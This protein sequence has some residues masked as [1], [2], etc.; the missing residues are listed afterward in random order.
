MKKLHFFILFFSL[1]LQAQFQI[2]GV[3]KQVKKNK[4]IP[5]AIIKTN[6]NTFFLADANGAFSISA[7][8]KPTTLHIQQAGFESTIIPIDDA[9]PFYTVQLNSIPEN[10]S[11]RKKAAAFVYKIIGAKK[12]NNPLQKLNN[13][14]FKSY[15][16]LLIT[17][18]YDS[19]NGTIDSIFKIK[20]NQRVLKKIDS[21]NYK[22]KKL[23]TK[24]DLYLTEKVSQFDF[25]GAHF[26]ERVL[27]SKMAGFKESI[28]EYLS[29][30][31]Q[32]FSIYDDKYELFSV[33][34][35]SPI[36]SKFSKEYEFQILDSTV[37]DNRKV[38]ILHFKIKKHIKTGLEGILY[39]DNE[40]FAV[41][42][43]TFKTTG[44]IEMAS[45]IDFKYQPVYK[46][47]FP[48]EKKILVEKGDSEN[49]FRFFGK[50]IAFENENKLFG[51][52][53]KQ[54][55]D[56]SYLESKTYYSDFRFNTTLSIQQ[57]SILID[58]P[59]E[60]NTQKEDFWIANRKE[61]LTKRE[62][63][64]YK[65]LDSLSLLKKVEKRIFQGRK[66]INGYFPLSFFD[67]NLRALESFNNYE[68]FRFGIGGKTNEKLSKIYKFEFYTAY[69]TRDGKMK[70]T[71][72][73]SLRIGGFSDSWVGF[74]YA[75]DINE[76]ANSEF[77]TEKK[78]LPIYTSQPRNF[79]TFYNYENWSGYIETKIIPKTFSRWQI[80]HS[81]VYPKFNYEF[82]NKGKTYSNFNISTAC[83]SIQWNPFS[84]YMQTPLGK[85]EIKK[86]FPKFT[87]QFTQ[88]LPENKF[89]TNDFVFTKIDFKTI[90]EKKYLNGQKL[91]IL[92]QTGIGFGNIPIT[93]LYNIGQNSLVNESF[94]RRLF[95]LV[96]DTSFE[97]MYFNEFYSNQYAY[98]QARYTFNKFKIA[99]RMKPRLA[100]VSRAAWGSLNNP[101]NHLLI[102]IKTLEKGFFE[103]GLEINK[104][105]RI[106]G[107][108][109]FYRYGPNAL[110]NFYDNFAAKF[111]LNFSL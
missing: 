52:D 24:Q 66:I 16:K 55:S 41:A 22:F 18:H 92:F 31:S 47:W 105:Y 99:R 96:T 44:M 8:E 29:L 107:L 4:P 72:D 61:P 38:S 81:Q 19:I 76:M 30:N 101:E 15:N 23:I 110:P 53:E 6:L 77:I 46:I 102:P 86:R 88:T 58:V 89:L 70:S 74:L 54:S 1:S 17:A 65:I 87:F 67:F 103:S 39:I 9:K 59:E 100:L 104:I 40:N 56:F 49:D 108:G 64:T 45:C 93:H 42:K 71:I 12:Q 43:A 62:L 83:F 35:K 14:Q 68:G 95:S 3:V 26:K 37:I 82:L 21:S 57:K 85:F 98:L 5:F 84:D 106:V 50:V 48:L 91:G 111:T 7:S 63:N 33:K 10:Q 34:F 2:N 109:V 75:N 90:Y 25:D 80:T 13:F 94:L 78:V 27:A 36:S 28:Y 69:G 20:K 11:E 51:A 73:N 97:T 79:T 32:S 60:S